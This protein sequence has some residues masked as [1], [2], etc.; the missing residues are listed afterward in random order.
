M[1][2]VG[3][4]PLWIMILLWLSRKDAYMADIKGIFERVNL[5]TLFFYSLP[6]L[7]LQA[8]TL[9]F[10]IIKIK[11]E[12]NR[13]AGSHNKKTSQ[14]V[15]AEIK[16]AYLRTD[17][18]FGTKAGG[19]VGHIAG[20]INGFIEK[21]AGVFILSADKLELIDG[22]KTRMNIIK[23]EAKYNFLAEMPELHYNG[24]LFKKA[25]SI[26]QKEKPNLIYQRYSLNNY[27]GVTLAGE[28]GLPFILEY[29]GSE[30][31][32]ARNWGRPL[33]FE[34][35]SS[36]IE[37]LNFQAADL[38]TVVSKPLKD[39]ITGRGIPAEKILVNPN[40]V[41]PER[42]R[43]DINGGRIRQQYGLDGKIIVGFIGTFGNWHGA[44]VLAKAAVKLVNELEAPR[45]AH[46]LFIG[47]GVKLP[48]TRQNIRDGKIEDRTTFTGLVPQDQ[49]PEYLAACDI[50][51]APHVPNPD[52]SPFFGSPTK[53]FEYMAMGRG[54]VASNLDQIGEV[55][56]HGR[57]A[58]LT[59]PGNAASLA[60]GILALIRD[61][62]LRQQLGENARAEVLAK[63]TWSQ[64][65]N[66]TLARLGEVLKE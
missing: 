18:I 35:L 40:G 23:P 13:L 41:D 24:Y 45:A 43:P 48:E 42:Y 55:L 33:R 27:T 46:F 63:Y 21:Y 19:S 59:E 50:L 66:R 20:V 36:K 58:W 37:L 26:F 14:K 49:G 62:R 12:I 8:V 52:G 32:V 65:V 51:I 2:V 34:K 17:F 11:S 44:E 25:C 6:N 5:G 38:I 28:F 22:E 29:N 7:L 64:H 54:I 56:E 3:K 16:L 31:W 60:E 10:E 61:E 15:A 53:L 1:D 30:V 4:S 47:D 57:T 39:E 9:P